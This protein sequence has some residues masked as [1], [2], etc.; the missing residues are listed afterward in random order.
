MIT[1]LINVKSIK[2]H[3][4]NKST[5]QTMFKMKTSEPLIETD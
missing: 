3:K 2:S 1:V 5:V 4:S